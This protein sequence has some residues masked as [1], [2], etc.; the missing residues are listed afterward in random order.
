MKEPY[1][2]D[3]GNTGLPQYT[4]AQLNRMA[5]ERSKAGFQLGFA[6]HRRVKQPQWPWMRLT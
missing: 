5:I 6:R 2:D 3:P 1:S 4:Q